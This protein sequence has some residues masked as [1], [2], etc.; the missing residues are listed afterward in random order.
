[1]AC[2]AAEEIAAGVLA[3]RMTK[4]IKPSGNGHWWCG[5]Y[6]FMSGSASSPTWCTSPVTPTT[7]HQGLSTPPSL[8]RLPIGSSPG[9]MRRD[10]KSTRLNSSHEWISYAVFCLKKKNEQIRAYYTKKTT[11]DQ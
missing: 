10:R 8:T 6:I 1:M 5:T 9:H 11:E 4:T 3:A 2:C 7:V